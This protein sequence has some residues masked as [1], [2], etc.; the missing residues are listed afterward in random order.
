MSD[1][2]ELIKRFCVEA[3]AAKSELQRKCPVPIDERVLYSVLTERLG[4]KSS[5]FLIDQKLDQ[6]RILEIV[7]DYFEGELAAIEIDRD[8]LPD[9]VF[10][11]L[12]EAEVKLNNQVWTLHRNDKDPFPSNPHAHIYA[13]G[14]KLD[15]SNGWTYQK[16]KCAGKIKAKDLMEIRAKFQEKL[17]GKG[18]ALPALVE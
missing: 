17:D 11:L 5:V 1:P 10:K 18:I 12:T 13:A 3:D 7:G 14:L 8:I 15:L 6:K 9:G 4:L 2:T 16:R